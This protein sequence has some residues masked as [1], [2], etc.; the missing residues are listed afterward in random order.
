M[1]WLK[2]PASSSVQGAAKGSLLQI[3]GVYHS[4]VILKA[5]EV[6]AHPSCVLVLMNA[7]GK[8]EPRSAKERL[9]E[10]PGEAEKKVRELSA[11]EADRFKDKINTAAHRAT[12]TKTEW[13]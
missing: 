9:S 10:R 5:V 8:R 4:C 7:G 2:S 12:E 13:A 1:R 6:N 3:T 11:L